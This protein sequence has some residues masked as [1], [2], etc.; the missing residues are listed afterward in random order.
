MRG[1]LM[2]AYTEVILLLQVTKV[3]KTA[4]MVA[5]TTVLPLN[6]GDYP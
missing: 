1:D 3:E 2:K 4:A 6:C 5:N